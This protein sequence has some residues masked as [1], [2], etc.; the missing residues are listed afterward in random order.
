MGLLR[1]LFHEEHTVDADAAEAVVCRHGV[2]T[3]RWDQNADIGH[4]DLATSFVCESCGATF[5]GDEGRLLL[6]EPIA[7][8]S[9]RI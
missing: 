3:A 9:R 5:S 8:G 4:Q 7:A 1:K 2:L 6:R